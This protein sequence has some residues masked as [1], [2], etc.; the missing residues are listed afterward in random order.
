[1]RVAGA[2]AIQN[3]DTKINFASYASMR[4]VVYIIDNLPEGQGLCT[5][6]S[7]APPLNERLPNWWKVHLGEGVSPPRSSCY[8]N[9][10]SFLAAENSTLETDYIIFASSA[11]EW[12]KSD[13][14]MAMCRARESGRPAVFFGSTMQNEPRFRQWEMNE[15]YG[16]RALAVDCN[17][18]SGSKTPFAGLVV[19]REYFSLLA[20]A[21][22]PPHEAAAK[23]EWENT[24]RFLSERVGHLSWNKQTEI[25]VRVFSEPSPLM[26]RSFTATDDPRK[27]EMRVAAI[28]GAKAALEMKPKPFAWI[29]KQCQGARAFRA[30]CRDVTLSNL[31]AETRKFLR[32]VRQ[33]PLDWAPLG[34]EAM[35]RDSA[36]LI[37]KK[38]AQIFKAACD[39]NFCQIE[40]IKLSLN[41]GKVGSPDELP[42]GN[43]NP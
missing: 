4:C 42:S 16:C 28:L 34:S 40:V 21:P 24:S 3:V 33:N 26:H 30:F 43:Q 25:K 6:G 14:K 17:A 32:F 2:H 1:M 13:L 15:V 9:F 27:R 38:A 8:R 36:R 7:G 29:Q 37:P 11:Q 19:S 22:V 18:H 23:H 10:R 20:Q 12:T 31:V 39:E 5:L 41:I 35:H